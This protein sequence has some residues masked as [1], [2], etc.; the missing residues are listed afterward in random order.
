MRSNAGRLPWADGL[1]QP[2]ADS[3]APFRDRLDE[4]YCHAAAPMEL[5]TNTRR[6]LAIES[7]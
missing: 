2:I 7:E 4:L 1:P 3:V 5:L 6:G